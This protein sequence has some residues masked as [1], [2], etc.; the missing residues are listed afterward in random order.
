[1]SLSGM[2]AANQQAQGQGEELAG[3]VE[4]FIASIDEASGACGGGPLAD[5]LT[6]L[7]GAVRHTTGLMRNRVA[8]T[9]NGAQGAMQAHEQGDQE[10]VQNA[11]R[12]Q[13]QA[14]FSGV[15]QSAPGR[16]R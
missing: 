3:S 8:S 6:R 11:A 5:A 4:V 10:M 1:M 12:Y 7:C 16:G 2:Q 14:Q 15:Q 13:G 9:I